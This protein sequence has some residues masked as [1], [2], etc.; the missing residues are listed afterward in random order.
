MAVGG[1]GSATQFVVIRMAAR[2]WVTP[3]GFVLLTNVVGGL[4]ALATTPN[5]PTWYAGLRKPAG[6]PPPWVFG[7][8]WTTLYLLMGVAAWL[9]YEARK[10]PGGRL[11]FGLFWVQLV[12]NGAWSPVFF[13]LHQPAWGLAII[14]IM[15]LAVIAWIAASWRVSKLAALLV[16]PYLGWILYASY[17]NYGIWSLNR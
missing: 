8:V 2:K 4:G 9:L 13:G 14:L 1:E 11:A 12:L 3:F 5:I 7:P 6:T 16:M 17:L 15:D 10:Q